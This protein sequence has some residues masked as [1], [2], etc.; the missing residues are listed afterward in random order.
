MSQRCRNAICWRYIDCTVTSSDASLRWC[1]GVVCPSFV[2]SR[3][4]CYPSKFL[5]GVHTLGRQPSPGSA[6]ALRG[7]CNCPRLRQAP[8]YYE[9]LILL[10]YNCSARLEITS[11]VHGFSEKTPR[12]SSAHTTGE[13]IK[14]LRKVSVELRWSPSVYQGIFRSRENPSMYASSYETVGVTEMFKKF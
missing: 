10:N 5:A 14:G 9:F 3:C 4:R 12:T 13:V 6:S 2:V 8:T 7:F 11:R 1:A